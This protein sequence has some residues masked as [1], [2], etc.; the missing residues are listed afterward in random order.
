VA[1]Q[2][3]TTSEPARSH[4]LARATAAD[5]P[6]AVCVSTPVRSSGSCIW[7]LIELDPADGHAGPRLLRVDAAA[8]QR[9]GVSYTSMPADV[10]THRASL[11]VT[12]ERTAETL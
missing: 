6:D 3:A 5:D 12:S 10:E 2:K 9:H 7:F 4:T 8:R 1:F 11:H